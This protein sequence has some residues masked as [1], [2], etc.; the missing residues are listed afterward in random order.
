MGSVVT[1]PTPQTAPAPLHETAEPQHEGM[2]NDGT[3]C[4][5]AGVLSSGRSTIS[6][7]VVS[8]DISLSRPGPMR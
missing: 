3:T 4:V 1:L 2:S 6:A 5:I 8:L 7:I